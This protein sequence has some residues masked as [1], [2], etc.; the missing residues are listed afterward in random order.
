MATLE[1]YSQKWLQNAAASVDEF[2]EEV[3]NADNPEK[4]RDNTDAVV[5]GTDVADN[6]F[7]AVAYQ[8]A[9]NSDNFGQD[10]SPGDTVDLELSDGREV[11]ITVRDMEELYENGITEAAANRWQDNWGES[12][13]TGVTNISL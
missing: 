11:T 9:V 7:A 10:V 13:T 1:E 12:L 6:A 2:V 5:D 8:V 3:Q 4:L